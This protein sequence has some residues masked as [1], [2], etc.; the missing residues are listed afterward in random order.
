MLNGAAVYIN[1]FVYVLITVSAFQLL[2]AACFQSFKQILQHR[3]VIDVS[4]TV[5]VG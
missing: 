3:N 1:L 4:Q 5:Y 2:R